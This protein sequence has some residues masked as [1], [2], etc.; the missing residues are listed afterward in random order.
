MREYKYLQVDVFT[1]KPFG[2]NPLAVFPYKTNVCGAL[3]VPLTVPNNTSLIGL[4]AYTQ[5]AVADVGVNA[6]GIVFSAGGAAKVGR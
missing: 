6:A 5:F 4:V 3:T 2:G 1:D